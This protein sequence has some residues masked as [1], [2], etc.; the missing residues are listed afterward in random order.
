[1]NSQNIGKYKKNN[2]F[3]QKKIMN[4]ILNISSN[5][6]RCKRRFLCI[7]L[8]LLLL[9]VELFFFW[10]NES[11]ALM[12]INGPILFLFYSL[13]RYEK[14]IRLEEMAIHLVIPILYLFLFNT[15][16]SHY[17]L[18]SVG[19]PSILLIVYGI[20]ILMN[21][22]RYKVN[23]HI[24]VWIKY[25]SLFS[26]MLG[27]LSFVLYFRRENI[28]N[29]QFCVYQYV[30]AILIFTIIYTLLLISNLIIFSI[31]Q[32]SKL[33][34]GDMKEYTEN[35][36][37]DT[38]SQHWKSIS[39][40]FSTSTDYLNPNFS[41]EDFSLKMKIE[42]KVLTRIL[43]QE[44]KISFYNLLAF[45]RIEVAKNLIETQSEIYT[46]E[47]IMI[48]SGFRSK[49]T[50]NRNFKKIMGITPSDYREKCFKIE[51]NV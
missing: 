30:I 16:F 17:K 20:L 46:L 8:F 26:I 47:Y 25:L 37:M 38:T 19:I 50:F 1:M 7:S 3:C 22:G 23:L 12:V 32:T 39:E 15:V 6:L 48:E 4:L 44:L 40:Y 11:I 43:N 2:L 35:L 5:D 27:I 42:K 24:S 51:A 13:F 49:S 28:F 21:R 9:V 34:L 45:K 33:V 36:M 41:F 10:E 29:V 14:V 31:E 18:Y